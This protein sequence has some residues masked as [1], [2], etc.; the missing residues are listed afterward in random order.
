[1]KEEEVKNKLIKPEFDGEISWH[2]TSTAG[3]NAAH[4]LLFKAFMQNK[5]RS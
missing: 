5:R 3:R 1:M 4:P 2:K